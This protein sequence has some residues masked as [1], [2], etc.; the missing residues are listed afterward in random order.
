MSLSQYIS[1]LSKCDNC[2]KV[3]E[4]LSDYYLLLCQDCVESLRT[5]KVKLKDMIRNIKSNSNNGEGGEL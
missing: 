3:T 2:G 4:H 5:G 1:G